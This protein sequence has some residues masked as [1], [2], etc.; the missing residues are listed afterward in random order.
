MAGQSTPPGA[1]WTVVLRVDGSKLIGAVSSCPA[2]PVEIYDTTIEGD[3]ITFKCK[4]G[5]QVLTF[6]GILSGD[7]LRLAWETQGRAF[8]GPI[9]A[10]DLREDDPAPTKTSSRLFGPSAPR[11]L[12][13]TRVSDAGGELAEI[14]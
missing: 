12:A 1:T 8:A 9:D 5:L 13:A 14:D 6:S 3:T 7:H 11:Q 4:S 10:K 2:S